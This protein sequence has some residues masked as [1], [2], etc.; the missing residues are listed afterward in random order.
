MTAGF[1]LHPSANNTHDS[2][3]PMR[4]LFSQYRPFFLYAGFFSLFINLLLLAPSIY[5][6]QVFDRVLT[7]RHEET[8]VLLTLITVVA[9]IG[10]M[11]LETVRSRVLAGAALAMDRRLGAVVLDRLIDGA[12]RPGSERNLHGLKDV[13]TLRAFLTGPG[14]QALFDAP[15]LPIFIIIIFMFHPMM[16]A[17][18]LAGAALIFL[19]ALANE[20]LTRGPIEQQQTAGR[21]AGRFVDL[22]LRNAEVV[23]ALGMKAGVSATWQRLNQEALKHQLVAG[24]WSARITSLS[25]F[26]RQMIQVVMLGVGAWLVIDL[27]VS[28][29][30]MIAATILL[31]RA[32]APVELLIQGWRSMVEARSAARRLSDLIADYQE[33]PATALPAPEGRLS[34]ERLVFGFKGSDR[35]VLKGV[36]FE[37]APGEALAV[38]GPSASGKSTLARLLVGVWKPLSGVVRLDGADVAAW[39]RSQLGPYVGYLPQDVELFAGTVR[40]NIARLE[41]C[42]DEAVIGAAIRANAHDMILRLPRGYDTAIGEGGASLSGGQRQRIAMARAL[43]GAPRLIVLDEPNASLDAEGED[44]LGRTLQGLKEQGATVVVITHR[45]GIVSG[46]DK[47][48][49]LRDGAV[50]YFGNK[51]AFIQKVTPVKRAPDT[52][53]S[54]DRAYRNLRA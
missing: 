54:A 49:V 3:E 5:M 12:V 24:Q 28:P 10:M 33:T 32:L 27:H 13:A 14:I 29:G 6:L 50:D 36:A 47:V 43:Y 34:A 7:S 30:V 11:L 31:G 51:D 44:S 19:L 48:L 38:L 2:I 8:L 52:G 22:S 42:A 18:A 45:P 25:K 15:W 26:S 37:L 39:S 21:R 40:E 23:G 46:V 16:G 1:E 9:L 20:R 41:Q 35:P 17:V 4:S 53:H